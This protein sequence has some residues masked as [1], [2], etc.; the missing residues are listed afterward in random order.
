MD[1]ALL[2]TG[3]DGER[4]EAKLMIT[5]KATVKIRFYVDIQAGVALEHQLKFLTGY[6]APLGPPGDGFE[7][8]AFD[9]MLPDPAAPEVAA[10]IAVAEGLMDES[11]DG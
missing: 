6:A 9:V 5:S 10:Q 7:R 4:G 11:D 1:S 8:V 3:D 2:H